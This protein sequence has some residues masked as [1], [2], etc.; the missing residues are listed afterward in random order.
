MKLVVVPPAWARYEKT[1]RLLEVMAIDTLAEPAEVSL[2]KATPA[3]APD[4][5]VLQGGR[6]GPGWWRLP[7]S[8]IEAYWNWSAVP[9]MPVPAPSTV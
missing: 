8:G 1:S 7:V 6:P 3:S 2:R 9:A 4:P 5:G